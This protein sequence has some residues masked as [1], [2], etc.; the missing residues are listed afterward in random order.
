MWNKKYIK[1]VFSWVHWKLCM[2]EWKRV[3]RVSEKDEKKLIKK[4][5]FLPF[6]SSEWTD[7]ERRKRQKESKAWN[8]QISR[9]FRILNSYE[10]VNEIE[11][12]T[13]H[14]RDE[15]KWELKTFASESSCDDDV[16][17]FLESSSSSSSFGEF[18]KFPDVHEWFRV[19]VIRVG[20]LSCHE[21][22][23]VSLDIMKGL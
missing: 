11:E 20:R 15:G 2:L 18:I 10:S 22:Y 14:S 8:I 9:G 19:R 16:C 6:F 4:I 23:L 12:Y 21:L 3:E 1:T 17:S 5:I 7:D 13:Q